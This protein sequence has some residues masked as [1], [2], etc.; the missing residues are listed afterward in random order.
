MSAKANVTSPEDQRSTSQL[1][2]RAGLERFFTEAASRL[3][4][5]EILPELSVERL[6]RFFSG[7]KHHVDLAEQL[8]RKLAS[9]FNVF[10]LIRPDENRL[11]DVLALLLDP[12]GAH[13]QG[14]LFLRLLIEKLD[15]GLSTKHTKRATVRREAPTYRIDKNRRRMDVLV[16][17]N[18]L[19]AIENK[20]NAEEQP[21]QV[22]D[23]LEHLRLCAQV[24]SVLSTLIYLTPS[25][26]PP[27]SIIEE[28]LNQAVAG[29]RLRCW[30][31]GHHLRKWLEACQGQC[32]APRFRDFLTDF[33]HYIELEIK[34][35][36][37][38][39]PEQ[40]AHEH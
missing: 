38:D 5:R 35:D 2:D 20:V 31:Y 1:V 13:G 29:N 37:A 15:T 18:D 8:D 26:D 39:N 34:R 25:G 30:S 32:E 28:D 9:G 16:D 33:I 22:E 36:S 40:T 12:R 6:D 21:E 7:A 17:A 24:H 19:V 11:S 23:Y 4:G 14:D 10:D 27:G 3:A